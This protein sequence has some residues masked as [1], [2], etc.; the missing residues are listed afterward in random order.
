MFLGWKSIKIPVWSISV[1]VENKNNL[2]YADGR[3]SASL[4]VVHSTL[5]KS[6][7]SK[8]DAYKQC[9]FQNTKY[10]ASSQIFL[11]KWLYFIGQIG[12]ELK[13]IFYALKDFNCRFY[14]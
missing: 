5:K 6:G 10:E 7:L 13:I 3:T 8:K 1:N 14:T 11:Y 2:F 9:T 4:L 12:F